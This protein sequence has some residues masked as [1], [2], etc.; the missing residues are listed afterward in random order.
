LV[1]VVPRVAFPVS[2]SNHSSLKRVEVGLERLL[3][4]KVRLAVLSFS[5]LSEAVFFIN[6]PETV[7]LSRD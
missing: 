5:H 7:D 1:D 6:V 4:E 2:V 3:H